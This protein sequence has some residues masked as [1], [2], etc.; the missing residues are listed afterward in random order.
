MVPPRQSKN[1]RDDDSTPDSISIASG[2]SSASADTFHGIY[3]R[4]TSI[5]SSIIF[6]TASV[7][8]SKT[9]IEAIAKDVVEA[10]AKFELLKP[11][12]KTISK[13]VWALFL[14]LLSFGLTVLGM[15][16]RHHYG[17]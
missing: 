9:K 8:D 12:A 16:L 15:W 17:W 7:D 11:I 10:K 14:L 5:E 1:L 2:G 6:I 13:G 4:L 3:Q